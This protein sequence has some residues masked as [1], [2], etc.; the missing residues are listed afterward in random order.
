VGFISEVISGFTYK[1]NLPQTAV[2][3]NQ[4]L[5]GKQGKAHLDEAGAP[6]FLDQANTRDEY[7]SI[8]SPK[9]HA[10]NA[11]WNQQQQLAQFAAGRRA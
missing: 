1:G 7:R 5:Y 6:G 10:S 8:L 2:S 4:H 9:Q 11:Q 3:D